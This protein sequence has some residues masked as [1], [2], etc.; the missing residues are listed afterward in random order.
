MNDELTI[1]R[2]IHFAATAITTGALVFRIAVE[3]PALRSAGADT[4]VRTHTLRVAWIGLGTTTVSGVIWFLFQAAAM[5]G[6]SFQEMMAGDVLSK[7]LSDTQFGFVA[8]IRLALAIVLAACLAYARV[9]QTLWPALASALGLVGAIAWVGHGGSTMGP[10]GWL[11]LLADVL[12]LLASAAWIGGLVPLGLLLAESRRSTVWDSITP[13]VTRRFST[14]GILSV[15]CLLATGVINTWSL[16][17]SLDALISTEYGRLL[18]LKIML[19][20]GMV[21]TATVNRQRLMPML[22]LPAE[23]KVYL[24]ALR[25]LERNSLIELALGLAIF[26]IVGVLGTIHPSIHQG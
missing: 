22:A 6:L 26:A 4:F 16:V 2:A 9:E 24:N 3:K 7:V 20:T 19:F 17:G 12:H 11:H 13:N 5:S 10:A 23:S 25:Q 18:T 21:G 15:G 14:M 1:I 8:E